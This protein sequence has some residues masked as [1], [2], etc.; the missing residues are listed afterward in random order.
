MLK[1]FLNPQAKSYLR[2]LESEFGESTNAIRLELNRFEEAG[3][4]QS[5]KEGNKKIYGANVKHPL[6]PSIQG[7]IRNYVG[8]DH[9]IENVVDRLGNIQ[10]VYLTGDWARGL[11]S[12]II[13]MVLVGKDIDMSF[14]IKL[15]QKAETFLGKKIR[16]VVFEP[17]EWSKDTM[18]DEMLLVIYGDK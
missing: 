15:C 3:L 12:N 4:L 13:D 2:G 16:Y 7:M 14:L 5:Q 11:E 1:F 9:L 6:F 10:A 8:I 18:K 17:E